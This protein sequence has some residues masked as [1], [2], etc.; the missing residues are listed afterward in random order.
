[1]RMLNCMALFVLLVGISGFLCFAADIGSD[2]AVTRFNTQQLVENG[3][4]I[5]GFAALAGG[6]LVAGANVLATFDSFFP[7]SG[8]I[9]LNF[10]TISLNQDLVLDNVLAWDH[11]GNINGN[12]HALHFPASLKCLPGASSLDLCSVTFTFAEVEGASINSV[13]FSFD[14]LWLAEGEGTDLDVDAVINENFLSGPASV[15]LGRTVNTVNWHPSKDFIAAGIE[16]GVGDELFTYTFDRVGE[17]L[18]LLD[19][20]D[21]GGVGNSVNEVSWHPDGGYLAVASDANANEL[22]VYVVDSAGNFGASTFVSFSPDATTVD[23]DSSGNFLAVGT[24]LG[25]GFDELRVYTFTPSPLGLALD[26]SFDTS[27]AISELRWNK[28]ALANGEIGVGSQGRSKRLRVFRHEGVGGLVELT[29][30]LSVGTQVNTVDWHPDGGC[31]VAGLQNNAEGT[32]GELRIYSFNDDDTLTQEDDHEFSDDVLTVDWS[33]NGRLLAVGDDGIGGSDPTV[34][35]WRFDGAFIASNLVIFDSIQLYLNSNMTF[36]FT[37]IKFTGESSIY[38]QGH[39]MSFSPTF[40]LFVD[41]N[42]SVHFQDVILAGMNGNK[43]QLTDTTSTVSF[44]RVRMALDEDYIFDIGKFEVLDEFIISG[45]HKF[46]YQSP[47]TSTILSRLPSAETIGNCQAGY[48]GSLIMD[49]NTTFSYDTTLS[50]TLIHLEDEYAKFIFNSATLAVT[51]SMQLTKG[52]MFFDGKCRIVG[53]DGLIFGDGTQAGNLYVE[54]LP[55][56]RLDIESGFL[57]DMNV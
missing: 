35:L 7:L 27:A 8:N 33:S 57:V 17:T 42:A 49:T 6:F 28:A 2:T 20:V 38:G 10:G 52:R 12:N 54:V 32:G 15:D 18:T 44:Q 56:A 29:T 11:L 22:I 37:S 16:A 34:S 14:N 46:I 19:S 31:I 55:A 40:T 3:D 43:L 13:D 9:D 24:K 30:G 39:I 50:S 25:G 4:R 51:S 1:M 26:A 23:W 45:D 36:D 47:C 41:S 48:T 5:A 53:G 21:L